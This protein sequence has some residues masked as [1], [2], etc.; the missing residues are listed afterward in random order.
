[1]I[2]IVFRIYLFKKY[3]IIKETK[4]LYFNILFYWFVIRIVTVLFRQNWIIMIVG[5]DMLGIRSYLLIVFYNNIRSINSG[6]TTM[7]TNRF[8]DIF[9][10]RF[11]ILAFNNNL[12][13]FNNKWNYLITFLIVCLITKRAQFPFSSWL[14][15]AIAAPTPVSSLVH[16]S[17]LVTAGLFIFYKID[18]LIYKNLIF[19]LFILSLWTRL[20]S[21]IIATLEID[22]KKIIALST[23]SQ[24]RFIRLAFS[25][26]IIYLSFLHILTHAI[27][28]ARLFYWAGINIH[29]IKN[30]QIFNTHTN[31]RIK[32]SQSFFVLV[33]ISLIGFPLALGFYSKEQILD[34]LKPNIRF[35]INLLIILSVFLTVIYTINF[36]KKIN[37]INNNKIIYKIR[38]FNII[39]T[40]ITFIMLRLIILRNKL[41]NEIWF[42][43]NFIIVSTG[44]KRFFLIRLTFTIFLSWYLNHLIFL[45][46]IIKIIYLN[47]FTIKINTKNFNRY[48][49]KINYIEF[50]WLNKIRINIAI[51]FIKES[52]S[53]IKNYN[54][55]TFLIFTQIYL[56]LN[57]NF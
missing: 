40:Y 20:Y 43:N 8:G 26:G 14:P 39:Y 52:K 7:N 53:I 5:W 6:F 49:N 54:F 23:L 24:I 18:I 42:K 32:V 13:N 50:G 44:W 31:K 47:F 15:L 30:E 11:I 51:N 1:M 41:I 45:N 35:V 12:I 34:F 27:F 25:L 16:S 38:Y 37:R 36:I 9:L 4:I 2:I 46:C 3:Y 28:K 29:N 48:I 10:L 33:F 22:I 17:T 56:I 21:G 55:I 19:L 57:N